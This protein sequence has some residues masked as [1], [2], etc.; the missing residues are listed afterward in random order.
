[1]GRKYLTAPL[2][3]LRELFDLREGK[4]FYRVNRCKG[5]TGNEA[6]DTRKDGYSRVTVDGQKLLRHRVIFAMEH[7]RW[8]NGDVDHREGLDA[9]DDPANLRECS[10]A[11]NMRNGRR[12]KNNT[13]GCP[14]VSWDSKRRKWAVSVCYN[15]RTYHYGRHDDLELADLVAQEARHKLFGAFAPALS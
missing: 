6:G 15:G 10:H 5:R 4:L 7:G 11:E 2:S 1:M 3:R 14:G 9:G 13:S 12:R 8:P